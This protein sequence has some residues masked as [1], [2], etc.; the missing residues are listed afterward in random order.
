[1]KKFSL[2]RLLH[3]RTMREE[4][5]AAEL[6]R[7]NRAADEAGMAC[8]AIAS[9]RRSGETQ[10]ADIARAGAT[11]GELRALAVVLDTMDA[12]LADARTNAQAANEAA[13]LRQEAH[14]IAARERQVLDRLYEQY[15]ERR[16]LTAAAQDQRAMDAIALSRFTRD[17]RGVEQPTEPSR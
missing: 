11:I 5:D 7:A 3:L 12:R 14:R 4:L 16:R 2:K 6:A 15:L 9:A 10:L 13:G 1:M 17:A 8:L